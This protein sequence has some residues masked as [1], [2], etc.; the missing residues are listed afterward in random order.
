MERV[1]I[2]EDEEKIRHELQ[3]FLERNGYE[4]V[5]IEDFNNLVS[6]IL[7]CHG[8]LVLLDIN[9]PLNDGMHICKE[10]RKVSSVPIM[11]LT[12]RISELDELISLNNGADQYITKPYNMQVLLARIRGLLRRNHQGYH[13]TMDCGYFFLH[14]T[15]HT[16]EANGVVVELTNNEYKILE[17][18]AQNRGKIVPRESLMNFLWD[19][20]VFVDDNTLNVNIGRL[21]HRLM[22]ID[23][24]DCIETK[25]GVGYLLK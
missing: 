3:L 18:L 15:T 14:T 6:A 4:V 23:A 25:R 1:I 24:G 11:M 16:V 7:E 13:E 2:V 12:S 19:S 8:D 5:A 21:R 22:E 17:C 10:L 20:D 9:L